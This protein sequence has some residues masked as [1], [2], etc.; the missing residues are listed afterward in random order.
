[1][2][3][4]PRTDGHEPAS[5]ALACESSDSLASSSQWDPTSTCSFDEPKQGGCQET[6]FGREK[7]PLYPR[8]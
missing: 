2:L 1:M 3:Q 7:E 4:P 8:E 5:E 6:V